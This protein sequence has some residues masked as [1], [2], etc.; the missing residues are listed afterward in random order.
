MPQG[1]GV[2]LP[3]CAPELFYKMPKD[4]NI[5]AIGGGAALHIKNE[6]QFKSVGFKKDKSSY[7]VSLD[8]ENFV[9]TSFKK[10][11]LI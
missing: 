11:S 7:E 10:V 8:K 2:R 9:E 1:V 4:R 3:L 6:K 5:I